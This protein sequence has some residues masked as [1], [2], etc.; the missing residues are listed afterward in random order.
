MIIVFIGTGIGSA[1]FFEGKLYRGSSFYAG[2][3]GH[4]K[5]EQNGSFSAKSKKNTLDLLASRTAI[6]KAIRKD[7]KKGKKSIL[8]E[9]KTS[10]TI[11]KSKTL[12]HAVQMKDPVAVKHISKASVIIGT[13]LGSITTLLNLDTIVLGGGVLEAMHGFM[14]PIIR[15]SFNKSV[16]PDSGKIVRIFSTKLG[17]DA[18]LYGGISLAEEFL[19]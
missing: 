4:I 14:I 5:L 2:E 17:D 16:I 8:Q 1:L 10:E 19:N 6:V 7:L 13:T 11:L 9:Y 15:E 12:A 3:I 18:A